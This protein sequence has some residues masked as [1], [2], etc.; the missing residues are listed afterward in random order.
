MEPIRP[1][2]TARSPAAVRATEATAPL[3]SERAGRMVSDSRAAGRMAAG[4]GAGA[5]ANGVLPLAIAST[6]AQ[7]DPASAP[8]GHFP[9][10]PLDHLDALWIQVAGTVCNLKCTHCFVSCG[11]GD[12]HHALMP[13]E[14][15][16]A[17]VAEA[18]ALGVKEFYFTGGEPFLHP[19]LLEI[20]EDTLAHGPC[21]V[22]TNGT[23]FTRRRLEGLARLS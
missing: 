17:R 3:M 10:Q 8:A 4:R 16:R 19:D 7:S 1:S 18:L 2:Q 5:P 13:R 14:E 9:A 15:V 22:L 23:L 6:S 20:L 11:P 12:D 21:T